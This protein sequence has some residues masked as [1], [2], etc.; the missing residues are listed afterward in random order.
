LCT[1]E[2]TWAVSEEFYLFMDLF[3]RSLPVIRQ[4]L[5]TSLE[6]FKLD[7]LGKNA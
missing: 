1:F 6:G 7:E 2:E 5:P 3:Y 4:D